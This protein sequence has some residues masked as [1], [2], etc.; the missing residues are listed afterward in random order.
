MQGRNNQKPDAGSVLVDCRIIRFIE[1]S[2]FSGFL[3]TIGE[4]N[5]DRVRT[6]KQNV[7]DRLGATDAPVL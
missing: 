4:I 5:L 7:G 1:F 6:E 2:P 3:H